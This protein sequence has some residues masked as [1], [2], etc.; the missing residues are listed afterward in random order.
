MALIRASKPVFRADWYGDVVVYRD[1][2]VRPIPSQHHRMCST[3]V[4]EYERKAGYFESEGARREVGDV[5]VL[6]PEQLKKYEGYKEFCCVCGAATEAEA[7]FEMTPHAV[8]CCDGV[9]EQ[10]EEDE[11]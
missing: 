8:C 10:V 6:P 1:G 3:C 4:G 9:H 5:T 7:V 2:T 11:G